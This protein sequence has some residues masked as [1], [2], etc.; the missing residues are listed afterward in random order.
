M[1]LTEKI[2]IRA[3]LTAHADAEYRVFQC[4]LMPNVDPAR[5]LGVRTPELR[6]LAKELYR[7]GEGIRWM[8]TAALPHFYYE[9][10][11]LHAFL[12]EQIRDYDAC[13]AA[14]DRFLPYVDNWATCDSMSPKVLGKHTDRLTGDIRRWLAADGEYTVRF[15][16]GCLMTWY[17]D[18]RFS[19]EYLSMAAEAVRNEERYYI[20]MM[21]AWFFAT[22]LTKQYE[23]AL[24][25]I[26]ENR[27]PTWVHNK[28]IQKAVESYR[29]PEERKAY[30]RTLKRK[31][32]KPDDA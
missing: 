4:K 7:S 3:L 26:A 20:R 11:N 5:V 17:L 27:L 12:I 16:I 31:E 9:E 1:E 19:E 25:W 24:P 21:A 28:S 23:A 32:A 8:D 6:E 22:A 15:G 10:N 14:L 30:L 29:V 13:I 18:D 2:Q